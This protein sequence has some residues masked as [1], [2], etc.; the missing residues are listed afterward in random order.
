MLNSIC[1]NEYK[2]LSCYGLTEE[3]LENTSDMEHIEQLAKDLLS[4]N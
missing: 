1:N 4:G 3:T 2:E